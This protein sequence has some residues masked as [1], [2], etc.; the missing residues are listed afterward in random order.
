MRR[1]SIDCAN[2]M[3]TIEIQYNITRLSFCLLTV[4]KPCVPEI[5]DYL[6]TPIGALRASAALVGDY[7]DCPQGS[8]FR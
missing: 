8:S 4:Q 2:N 5:A 7:G 6:I 1:K 3:T